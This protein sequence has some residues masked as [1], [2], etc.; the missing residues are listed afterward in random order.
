MSNRQY[1]IDDRKAVMEIDINTIKTYWPRRYE[2]KVRELI[3]TCLENAKKHRDMIEQL[4]SLGDEP[5]NYF[6]GSWGR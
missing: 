2:K 1:H 5:P 4:E 3:K 6:F